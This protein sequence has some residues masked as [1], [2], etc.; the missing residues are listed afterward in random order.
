MFLPT[1][2]AGAAENGRSSSPRK[3]ISLSGITPCHWF[4]TVTGNC[5]QHLVASLPPCTSI[6]SGL[7]PQTVSRFGF[8]YQLEKTQAHSPHFTRHTT[9]LYVDDST[10]RCH[11]S[12][13]LFFSDPP[14]TS[15][16]DIFYSLG[17]MQLFGIIYP[18]L[19]TVPGFRM[20]TALSPALSLLYT[21]ALTCLR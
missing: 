14:P 10:V 3:R 4:M 7:C 9:V 2:P 5:A 17:V 19:V 18:S 20:A 16:L 6:M 8:E 1:H 21:M 13:S 12:A 11:S 15:F